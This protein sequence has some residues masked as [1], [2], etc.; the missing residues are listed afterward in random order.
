MNND[1]E[2][3]KY[4]I[5]KCLPLNHY[6]DEENKRFISTIKLFP[7]LL[8]EEVL[9]LSPADLEKPYRPGGW[10]VKQ[11]IHHL[12]DSHM[13]AI[14]RFKLTLTEENPTIKPYNE[15]AF[16]K[17]KDYE[18]PVEASLRILD[19]IHLHWVFILEALQ[20]KDFE[21]TY[22]HPQH[23]LSFNLYQA[24]ATYDWHCKHHFAHI[25]LVSKNKFL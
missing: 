15:A 9:A 14:L 25:Q 11:V 2:K 10:T 22:F 3:L 18:L 17:L 6:T 16:A 12:A 13:N 8:K 23:Q 20:P 21:R 1:L 4:P 24:L 7:S 19:G 5:G